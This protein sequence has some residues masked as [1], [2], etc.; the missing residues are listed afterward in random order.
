MVAASSDDNSLTDHRSVTLLAALSDLSGLFAP[1]SIGVPSHIQMKLIFYAAQVLSTPGPLLRALANELQDYARA[2]KVEAG[3]V[4][5]N[6]SF[7]GKN[8]DIT[9]S[10]RNF[11]P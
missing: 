7:Q 4:M 2:L 10:S 1:R 8:L 3:S 6:S 9:T 11:G 5:S